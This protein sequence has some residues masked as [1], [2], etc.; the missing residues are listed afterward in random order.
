MTD[1]QVKPKIV[2]IGPP[3]IYF[4][5]E[6]G[7]NKYGI[8]SVAEALKWIEILKTQVVELMAENQQLRAETDEMRQHITQIWSL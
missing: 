2:I 4:D 3:R 1:N 5:G 7:M 6:N 8:T